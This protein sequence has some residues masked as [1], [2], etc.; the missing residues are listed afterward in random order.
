MNKNY[1]LILL[2]ICVL[3]LIMAGCNN[4]QGGSSEPIILDPGLGNDTIFE[5]WPQPQ[6]DPD[7]DQE[8]NYGDEPDPEY[9]PD[10]YAIFTDYGLD[11]TIDNLMAN[12]RQIVSYYY[13]QTL[14]YDIGTF[15]SYVWYKDGRMLVINTGDGINETH[16]YFDFRAR[17]IITHTPIQG[18]LALMFRFEEDDPTLPQ[19]FL[20]QDYHRS[21]IVNMDTING[22]TVFVLEMPNGDTLWV[23]TRTGFPLQIEFIDETTGEPMVTPLRNLQLNQVTAAD[24]ELPAH[25]EVRDFGLGGW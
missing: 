17:T 5:P 24:V 25:I 12:L 15:H 16:F 4:G 3:I 14:H 1:A 23:S 9:Q 22:Q 7:F 2:L 13:E 8:P 18:D 10:P 6:P 11:S 20:Y 19:V 21:S